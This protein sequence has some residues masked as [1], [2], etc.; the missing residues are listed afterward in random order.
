MGQNQGD[1]PQLLIDVQHHLRRTEHRPG[2]PDVQPRMGEG[3]EAQLC[4]PVHDAQVA[5]VVQLHILVDGVKLDALHP[6]P[7]QPGELLFPVR[8]VRVH[9][10]KG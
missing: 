4:R 2:E 1:A 10:A 5:Q 9:T 3:D 8:V 7:G 6:R